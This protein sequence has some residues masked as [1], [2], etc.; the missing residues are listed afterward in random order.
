[1]FANKRGLVNDQEFRSIEKEI[2]EIGRMI[3]SLTNSLRENPSKALVKALTLLAGF[4]FPQFFTIPL[5]HYSTTSLSHASVIDTM[6]SATGWST[7]AD[8]TASAS[9]SSV[10]GQN[11]NAVKLTYALTGGNFAGIVKTVA[12]TNIVAESANSLR[13]LYRATG[14]TNTFEIKF[15][16]FDST[17]TAK[18]DKMV[19]KFLFT[20]DNAWH[21]KIVPFTDFL[22]FAD[23]NDA[24]NSTAAARLT[25]GPTRENGNVGSGVLFLDGIQL[26][27]KS[28]FSSSIDS[29]ESTTN[30]RGLNTTFFSGGASG[31]GSAVYVTSQAVT[32]SQA[33]ELNFSVTTTGFA[34]FEENLGGLVAALGTERLSFTAKGA[35]GGE[36]LRIEIV[37]AANVTVQ[38]S[39]TSYGTLTT[40]YQTFS[41]P[42]S[43]FS[44]VDLKALSKVKLL[45]IDG[46]GTG[47]IYVDDLA[48][49]GAASS[50]KA[51]R[52]LEE[53]S[54][55][56]NQTTYAEF[57][58][59]DA[60]LEM[61][62][63]KDTSAPGAAEDNRV[64]RME[65]A[66][67]TSAGIPYAVADRLLGPN[68]Q[69]EPLLRFRFNGTGGDNHLE[70]K[71]ED[72][73]GTVYLRKFAEATD[74]GGEWKTAS[75]PMEHFGLNAAGSDGI[76]H[77]NG[78]R[79]LTF[80]AVKGE[81][82]DGTL[83]IDHIESASPIAFEKIGAGAVLTRVAVP[84][85]P[86]SPN[87][88]GVEDTAR[89][90]Y[91]LSQTARVVL[92]FFDLRGRPFKTFD[93][94]E[95]LAGNHVIEW[96]GWDQDGHRASNGVYL[97]RLEAD[98]ADGSDVF[99]QVIGV[100]R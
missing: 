19:H 50:D 43:D 73:D 46:A 57:V 47:R 29:F 40:S 72:G 8:G 100:I 34:G 24:F 45:F 77:L 28:S 62:F 58:H 18:S 70:I 13:F 49:T 37:D 9:T 64:A 71:L 53:F 78:I 21:E 6:D 31:S 48:V 51:V 63:V 90:E 82:G 65:Y 85:N 56:E 36:P 99:K 38:R 4:W 81:S 3:S 5:F 11:G 52:T 76:L 33:L 68:F 59:P 26:Y 41:I 30:A 14:V 91:T 15:T 89:F 79:K 44:G 98:G 20:P 86:F 80:T 96:D 74:T 94:G 54:L 42:L 39:L 87:G 95:Q 83:A 93:M 55:P 84:N 22:T 25:F 35:A 69:A 27:Q 60:R 67:S 10:Q 97:F 32:G 1:M 16:D 92:K 75:I 66:F 88:D 2:D 17:D 61:T 23:G 12:D 7:F